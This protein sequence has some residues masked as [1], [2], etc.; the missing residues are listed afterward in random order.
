MGPPPISLKVR[1]AIAKA[2]ARKILHRLD[3]A[4]WAEKRIRSR[5]AK[6]LGQITL[7]AGDVGPSPRGGRAQWDADVATL[8]RILRRIIERG[9]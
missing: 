2:E 5:A 7:M 8:K 4:A 6:A 1:A 3:D 9:V